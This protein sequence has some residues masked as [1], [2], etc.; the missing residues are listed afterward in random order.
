[1]LA[2]AKDLI[3]D[4]FKRSYAI[5]SFNTYN[6]EVTQGIVDAASNRNAPV[7]IMVSEGT[8]EYAGLK[9]ITHIVSTIAKNEA[10]TVPVA[11]HLDHGKKFHS[12]VET[13]NAGFTSV[14]ID[15]SSLAIDENIML[16]K[17]IVE[18]A[19]SRN[20]IVQG[21]VG[22]IPG[23]HSTAEKTRVIKGTLTDVNEAV[24]FVAE[25]SVDTL[26]ISIGNCHGL[27][28]AALHYDLLQ[29]LRQA[30]D[31]PLVLHGGSGIKAEDIKRLIAGGINDVNIDSELRQAFTLTLKKVMQ[32]KPDE[33][34][35]RV[36]IAPC[37]RAVAAVVE[38]KMDE[39]GVSGKANGHII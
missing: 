7:I 35:P 1:M 38:S 10:V 25:T 2:H 24:R 30:I 12:V 23:V 17:Q 39:F 6:L 3:K 29:Q 15:G 33:L 5:G 16:T 14:Q 19:H 18:Y 28:E 9:P 26:A 13:I 22:R 21:E 8:I 34:D 36:L 27:Y 37:R 32:E 11:L 4:A 20:V 31:I